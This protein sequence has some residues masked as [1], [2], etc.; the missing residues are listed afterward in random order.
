[1]HEFLQYTV[2][3][4]MSSPVVTVRPSTRLVEMEELFEKHGFNA[5]PVVDEVDQLVGVVGSMD[6]LKA[7]CFGE[8]TILPPYDQI[9]Q[10]EVKNV[11]Q[12][13]I[14]VVWPRTLLTRVVQKIVDTG[15]KSF[16]VVEDDRLTGMVSR[17]DV[18]RALRR[19]VA[20]IRP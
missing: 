7:F 1:M 18:I 9:M 14:H 10:T 17:E 2:E 5:F 16:P 8:D 11:M 4:V 12:R 6:L 13:D 19:G 20:G 3:D 15:C